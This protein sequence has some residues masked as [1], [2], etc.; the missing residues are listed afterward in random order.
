VQEGYRKKKQTHTQKAKYKMLQNVATER[1]QWTEQSRRSQKGVIKPSHYAPRSVSKW[2]T[3]NGPM[4]KGN[5]QQATSYQSKGRPHLFLN[6]FAMWNFMR[7]LKW[8]FVISF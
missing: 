5:W 6:R 8:K 7:H 1:K 3:A 4:T 2:P